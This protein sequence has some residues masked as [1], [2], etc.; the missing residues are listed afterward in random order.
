MYGIA[1]GLS[2]NVSNAEEWAEGTVAIGEST[3]ATG[4]DSVAVGKNAEAKGS[5][6]VALGYDAY[7]DG[8]GSV[9]LGQGVNQNDDTL[10]FQD[11]VVIDEDGYLPA[12]RLGGITTAVLSGTY[13]DDTTFSFEVYTK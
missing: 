11:K 3:T 6:S 5:S 13:D 12:E 9:Q 7:V 4:T 8:N 1:I 2:A 10:Q